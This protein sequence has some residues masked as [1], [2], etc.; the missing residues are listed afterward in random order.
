[1]S[2]I[3]KN[4]E[5]E[6]IGYLEEVKNQLDFCKQEIERE[7]ILVFDDKDFDMLVDILRKISQAAAKVQ[8]GEYDIAPDILNTIRI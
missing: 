5:E 1:M 7:G 2:S 3:L 8:E 6:I 4:L